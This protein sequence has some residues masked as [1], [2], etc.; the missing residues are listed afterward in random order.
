MSS[1]APKSGRVAWSDAPQRSPRHR[2]N[3]LGDR[4]VVAAGSRIAHRRD[5]QVVGGRSALGS[6]LVHN[7]AR[8]E[9]WENNRMTDNTVVPVDV[10][11][12]YAVYSADIIK[13]L[14]DHQVAGGGLLASYSDVRCIE[15]VGEELYESGQC[16]ANAM[17]YASWHEDYD[18]A[19]GPVI[20]GYATTPER[21]EPVAHAWVVDPFGQAW[22]VT[23]RDTSSISYVGLPL[24][25]RRTAAT[26]TLR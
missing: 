22:D 21:G 1:V 26:R 20:V 16:L 11:A 10:D 3:D 25:S 4:A 17:L 6:L 23:W 7:R 19:G 9:R 8:P 14:I 12:A 15:E 13:L 24:V 5:A 18:I 2:R